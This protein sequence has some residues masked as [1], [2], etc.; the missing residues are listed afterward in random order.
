[1]PAVPMAIVTAA[2]SA[3]LAT[4]SPARVVFLAPGNGNRRAGFRA[5]LLAEQH[6]LGSRSRASL[7][8]RRFADALAPRLLPDLNALGAGR[9]R[10]RKSPRVFEAPLILIAARG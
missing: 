9:R 3:T 2:L 7:L 5:P 1:M 8:A 4:L 6:T 10:R